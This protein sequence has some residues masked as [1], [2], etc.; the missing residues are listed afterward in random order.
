MAR[1]TSM[2]EGGNGGEKTILFAT[3]VSIISMGDEQR[4]VGTGVGPL[5]FGLRFLQ[6]A[7]I[8]SLQMPVL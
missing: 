2:I 6:A 8:A 3:M 7:I 4:Q 1:A 5:A